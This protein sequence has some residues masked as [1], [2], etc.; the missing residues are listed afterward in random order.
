MIGRKICISEMWTNTI[1]REW[2]KNVLCLNKQLTTENT[3]STY[4]KNYM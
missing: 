1:K 3:H 2:D 4:T